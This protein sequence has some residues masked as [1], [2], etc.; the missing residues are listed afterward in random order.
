MRNKTHP[1][2]KTAARAS[3]Y[4]ISP[5]PWNPTIEYVNCS[6][7]SQGQ[8]SPSRVVKALEPTH[9]SVQS[10]PRRHPDRQV[11]EETHEPAREGRNGG[12]RRDEVS[13]DLGHAESVGGIRD[14]SV[15]GRTHARSTRVRDD[16]RVYGDLADRLGVRQVYGEMPKGQGERDQGKWE[17]MSMK[18]RGGR[19]LHGC[20]R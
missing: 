5:V 8:H 7:P 15:V 14:T 1:S 17:R 11:C 12:R 13:P 3:R 6:P 2:M 4:E 10:Q 18:I 16:G 9:V 19:G 20:H